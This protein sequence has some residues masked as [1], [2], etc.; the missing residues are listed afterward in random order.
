[1]SQDGQ[2]WHPRLL[3]MTGLSNFDNFSLLY[4]PDAARLNVTTPAEA[5]I[6]LSAVG[7]DEVKSPKGKICLV[8]EYYRLNF[9]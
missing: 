4:A 6:N 3:T 2:I 8:N 7:D 1:M 5:K 9:I